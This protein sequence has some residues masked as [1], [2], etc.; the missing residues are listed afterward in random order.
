MRASGKLSQRIRPSET[1]Q[2]PNWLHGSV[3]G[4]R[5]AS[6][7]GWRFCCVRAHKR[8]LNLRGFEAA[9]FRPVNPAVVLLSG[10]HRLRYYNQTRCS[11]Y[12]IYQYCCWSREGACFSLRVKIVDCV[13]WEPRRSFHLQTL[14]APSLITIEGTFSQSSMLK[15]RWSRYSIF[16]ALSRVK[17]W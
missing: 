3:C 13:Y 9:V 4:L 12:V 10:L 16:S 6:D 8:L 15:S 2:R 5:H 1:S 17:S 14:T 7:G 11:E